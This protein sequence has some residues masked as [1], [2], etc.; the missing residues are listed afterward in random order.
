[1]EELELELEK[2]ELLERGKRIKEIREEALKINK[3]QLAEKLGI[4]PQFL[5]LVESGKGNLSYRSLKYLRDVSGYS[6]DYIL[7]GFDDHNIGKVRELLD[8][9]SEEEIAVG[10]DSVKNI[11][12]LIKKR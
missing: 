7:F 3:R 9:Y 11:I 1:M 10:I 2:Q 5:G 12:K 4:S 6:T 8:N